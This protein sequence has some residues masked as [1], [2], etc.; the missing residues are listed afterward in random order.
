MTLE[1]NILTNPLSIIVGILL[2]TLSISNGHADET[3][4][5]LAIDEYIDGFRACNEANN[6][7]TS[8]LAQAKANFNYYTQQLNKAIA[9]DEAILQ[10]NAREMS[11]NIKYCKRVESNIQ[12]AE[13]T[14]ILEQ[15]IDFCHSSKSALSDKNLTLAKQEISQYQQ[16]KEQALIIAPDLMDV[17]VLASKIR[18]CSRVEE[19]LLKAEAAVAQAEEQMKKAILEYQ[20]FSAQCTTA[21]QFTSKPNFGAQ[22]LS[23]AN[24]LLSQAQKRKKSARQNEKAFEL[25]EENPTSE[26]AIA[27]STLIKESQQCEAEVSSAIRRVTKTKRSH[28]KKLS[29]ASKSLASALLECKDAQ[30]QLTKPVTASE[31][32]R[33][34][35]L[36]NATSDVK[37]SI[38]SNA[39]LVSISQ[40]HKTWPQSKSLQQ[41]LKNTTACLSILSATLKATKPIPNEPLV[42]KENTPV[43]NT[44]SEAE[45][46]TNTPT[47]LTTAP[48]PT[49]PPDIAEESDEELEDTAE[50]FDEFETESPSQ[51]HKSWTDIIN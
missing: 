9:I 5:N 3:T 41:N 11:T 30:K 34:K 15:G 23:Q 37:E 42:I 13:A 50:E 45:E 33:L 4:L 21:R 49:T 24:R 38:A 22:Q 43:E 18:N 14:P 8:D 12:R 46:P 17:F 39:T 28:Q 47:P 48:Q 29:N 40:S 27:L 32:N 20:D 7:R 25:A 36:Y 1:R 35:G 6:L 51:S 31:L 44:V 26:N 10:T 2:C 16:L 19:K